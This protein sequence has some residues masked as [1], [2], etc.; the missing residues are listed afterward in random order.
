MSLWMYMSLC[1]C[2][3]VFVCVCV[4]VNVLIISRNPAA[5][6]RGLPPAFLTRGR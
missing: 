4:C 6:S 2:V 3:C 1:V 5:R